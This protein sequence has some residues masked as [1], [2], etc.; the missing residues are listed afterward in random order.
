[1]NLCADGMEVVGKVAR[2]VAPT[3]KAG[4]V[5]GWVIFW[6]AASAVV[7][8]MHVAV[9]EPTV[10]PWAERVEHLGRLHFNE[11]HPWL[12]EV[13]VLGRYHGQYHWAEGS[14][15]EDEGWEDR[16]FRMGGQARLF[17]RLT[18]HAQMVSGSDFD[19]FYN[20]FTEL[21]VQWGFTEAMALTVGQ[22]KHRF[23]H[24]RTTSSR[25]I[26][27]V[28]R[29]L[30]VNMINAEYTPAVTLSGSVGRVRYYAGVFSNSTGRDMGTAFTE[31]DGG[32][33]FLASVTY[34]LGRVLGADTAHLIGGMVFSDA[35][36]NSDHLDYFTEGLSTALVLTRG[37]VSLL[38][39][40]LAGLGNDH[41][42]T[43]G[44]SLQ[45]GWFL[46]RKLQV[47]GRYQLAISDEDTG[48]RAQRR[49]ER[50]A[51]LTMGDLY[52][53]GYVGA[54]YYLAEHR[55][56]VMTGVEYATLGGEDVWT[57]FTGIRV[58]WGPHARGPF[59]MAQ[60]LKPRGG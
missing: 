1:M 9:V 19:P 25:Y 58:F 23:T 53:A 57:V 31:F 40:V 45:P 18:L 60:V 43:L 3:V 52:Q 44:L 55:F 54:N 46:T 29:S 13:W 6:G 35:N 30:L 16:R 4:W 12:Q 38:T 59:P 27:T 33:S 11:E 21:W 34:D 5:L 14:Q 32:G 42:D 37:P 50:P 8:E 28:E 39:E 10:I 51:G 22:Q 20:G 48:I 41:G 2:G 15:G 47:V 49:Y 17:D 26:N 36:Q 24:E 56:K 7:G